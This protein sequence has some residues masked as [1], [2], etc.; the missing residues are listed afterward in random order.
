MPIRRV[1]RPAVTE[2]GAA[3]WSNCLMVGSVA[4][5]AGLTARGYDLKTIEG[6]DEYEQT[7]IIFGK[8]KALVQAADGK[9][10]DIVKLTIFVTN[11]ANR[12]KIAG[13]ILYRQPVDELLRMHAPA[14]AL[15]AILLAYPCPPQV[16]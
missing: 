4:Y 14:P 12:Q 6:A 13:G 11:I 16:A 10:S 5:F 8:F 1:I 15:A 7:R 9:M 2:A 3:L